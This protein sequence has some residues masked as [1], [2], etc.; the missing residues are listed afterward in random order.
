M[1]ERKGE[2]SCYFHIMDAIGEV[3]KKFTENGIQT[4]TKREFDAGD[5]CRRIRCEHIRTITI[6]YSNFS[7]TCEIH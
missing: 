6:A 1:D 2:I 4:I 5:Y 7:I 3:Y